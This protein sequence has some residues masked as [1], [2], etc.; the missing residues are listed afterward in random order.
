MDQQNILLADSF[1]RN[2]E[3]SKK[4]LKEMF[5]ACDRR[6]RTSKYKRYNWMVNEFLELRGVVYRIEKELNDSTLVG[7]NKYCKYDDELEKKLSRVCLKM[8]VTDIK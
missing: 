8:A 6:C 4:I 2:L 1:V 7:C 5:V 3:V